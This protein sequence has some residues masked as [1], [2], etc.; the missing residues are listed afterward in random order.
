M[1]APRVSS[2]ATVSYTHLDVYKRQLLRRPRSRAS[3]STRSTSQ[4][5]GS[6]PT[7]RYAASPLAPQVGQ[8]RRWLL[9]PSPLP[10]GP[11]CMPHGSP[12]V[13]YT[14]LD[15][16][17]RQFRSCSTRP[18]V[19]RRLATSTRWSRGSARWPSRAK[20]PTPWANCADRTPRPTRT[21]TGAEPRRSACKICNERSLPCAT[22]TTSEKDGA[23]STARM[24]TDRPGPHAASLGAGRACRVS[25]TRPS[26]GACALLLDLA[27][28]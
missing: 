20:S 25:R 16:Y 19:A 4:S 24:A 8:R 27:P 14:H 2:A 28:R 15:V 5:R 18:P 11:L 10:S 23:Y 6:D 13:S 7:R 21:P 9:R 22:A 17:K 12:T 1:C 3:T 26:P